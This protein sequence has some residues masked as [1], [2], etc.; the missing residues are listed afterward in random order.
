MVALVLDVLFDGSFLNANCRDE[1]SSAPE[2][3]NGKLFGFLFQPRRSLTFQDLDDIAYRV[4]G[5][6]DEVEVDVL[7]PNVPSLDEEP[8]P[9][10]NLSQ[11]ALEFGFDEQ[12]GQDLATIPRSPYNMIATSIC[13][14][15]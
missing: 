12:T 13:T 9:S 14:M 3:P 11:L 7:V 2:R 15:V 5:R 6:D 1:I 4:L 10:G 8:F